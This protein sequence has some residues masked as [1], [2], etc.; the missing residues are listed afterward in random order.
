MKI[1]EHLRAAG[2]QRK[3]ATP[4][5]DLGD[6]RKVFPKAQFKGWTA[7][8]SKPNKLLYTKGSDYTFGI[9]DA[10]GFPEFHLIWPAAL[11]QDFIPSGHSWAPRRMGQDKLVMMSWSDIHDWPGD[12]KLLQKILDHLVLQSAKAPA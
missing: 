9:E 2:A 12:I 3:A 6:L 8:I 7:K 10:G 5:K 4:V 1:S 11:G